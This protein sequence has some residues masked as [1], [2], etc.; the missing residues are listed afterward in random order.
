MGGELKQEIYQVATKLVTAGGDE[1][2]SALF[3]LA[4]MVIESVKSYCNLKKLP[5]E[6]KYV[7]ARM[8]AD[9]YKEGQ[10]TAAGSLESVSEDGRTVKFSEN[11]TEAKA[12][13]ENRV[14]G[15]KEIS[16][17]RGLYRMG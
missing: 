1:A 15:M 8:A 11:T 6:L 14:G 9:I 5:K 7:V 17:F 3:V 13:I 16:R 2:D 12:R 4:D 10:N